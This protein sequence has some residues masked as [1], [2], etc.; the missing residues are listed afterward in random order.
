MP[1]SVVER[2]GA[3]LR[4]L[5]PYVLGGL[6]A[7]GGL[8]YRWI[9]SRVGRVELAAATAPI[10]V[11]VGNL[12]AEAFHANTLANAHQSQ[13]TALWSHTVE[14][15]AELYV[16]RVYGKASPGRRAELIEQSK[17]FYAAEYARQLTTHTLDPAEACRLALLADFR[18]TS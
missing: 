12:R 6:I 11:E 15:E 10:K 17:K 3:V 9:E 18:P 8:G 14:V 4:W 5:A 13:L 1:R 2:I 16:Y 7:L